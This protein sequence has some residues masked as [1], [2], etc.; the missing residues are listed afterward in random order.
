VHTQNPERRRLLPQLRRPPARR[1]QPIPVHPTPL[2]PHRK[3]SLTSLTFPSHSPWPDLHRSYLAADP[4]LAGKLVS[5]SSPYLRCYQ[6]P[7]ASPP[8]AA[9][10]K[11]ELGPPPRQE[12]PR[13]RAPLSRRLGRRGN[14][15]SSH[16]LFLPTHPWM[17]REL[18]VPVDQ[19]FSTPCHPPRW[20]LAGKHPC[21]SSPTSQG[22]SCEDFKSFKGLSV[23][24]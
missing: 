7:T 14:L 17:R 15:T 8:P 5:S 2:Q 6:A 21:S 22:Y 24:F 20:N 1:G 3:L 10:V 4:L 11:P 9:A 23:K 16:P 12:L 19:S 13:R 18:L